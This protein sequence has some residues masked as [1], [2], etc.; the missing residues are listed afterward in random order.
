VL[1]LHI[2]G[3]GI[4]SVKYDRIQ[5]P[6]V[7]IRK[8]MDAIYWVSQGLNRNEVSDKRGV[9]RNSVKTFIKLYNK[10]GLDAL[11]SFQYRGFESVLMGHRVTLETYFKEHPFVKELAASLGI[12][13]VFLPPYSPNLN[14]IERVWRFIKKDV[15]GTHYF[16]CLKKFHAALKQTLVD[17]YHNHS[18]INDMRSLITPQFQTFA[19]NILA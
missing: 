9:H 11:R 13:L 14:L 4:Q 10:D 15:L 6:I 3:V 1:T 18:T 2:S 7:A 8:R 5:N 17:I 16:E 12:Q 19:Q